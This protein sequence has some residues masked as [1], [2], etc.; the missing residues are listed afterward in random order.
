MNAAPS[1]RLLMDS[2][3]HQQLGVE[4]EA[5]ITAISSRAQ[6]LYLTRQL[7]CT[8]AVVVALNHGLNGGLSEAQA[9]AMAAPFCAAMGESG[10]SCGALSGAEMACGL[11]L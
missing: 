9:V 10:C 3:L 1:G 4:A 6:N 8:E 2:D 11:F 7:L 5:L